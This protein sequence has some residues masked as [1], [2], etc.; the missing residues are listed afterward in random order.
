MGHEMLSRKTIR[1][2]P[3]VLD[4]E[5]GDWKGEAVEGGF[6]ASF[7][8][9]GGILVRECD[10]DQFVRREGAKRVLDRLQR[11]GITDPG[12]NVVGRC[13]F[14]KLVG[15]TGSLSARVVVGVCQPVKTGDVGSWRDDEQLCVLARVCTDRPAQ[16]GG[17]DGD[18]GDDEQPTRHGF[19]LPGSSTAAHA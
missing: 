19:R 16:S 10:D 5:V 1:L 6:R 13:R 4:D 18:G 12:L 15:P 17:R 8:K 3:L 11:V 9:P 7:L 2:R 14:R